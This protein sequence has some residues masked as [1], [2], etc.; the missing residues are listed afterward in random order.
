MTAGALLLVDD[1]EMN[2][3]MLGRRLELHGYTITQAEGGRQALDLLDRQ[4]FDLVL[5]DVMM[6]ELNAMDVLRRIRATHEAA[7]LPVIMVTAKDQ[8]EDVVEAFHLGANDYVTKPIDFPVALAR[9]ATQVSHKKA[10]AALRASEARFALAARG[11]ND[12]LWDWDLRTNEI[13]FSPRWQSML[14]YDAGE[15]GASPDDWFRRTHPDDIDRVRAVIAAHRDGLT[16][17]FECEQRMLHKDETYRWVLCRGL[18]IRDRTGAAERMAG[19]LTDITEGKVVDS[20]TGL[21]NRILFLDRLG[22]VLER[23][24]RHPDCQWAVLFLD[25][26]RFKVI[27][28]SL[29]HTVGDQLLVG[30]AR[31]L[32]GCLRSADTVARCH[33]DHTIARLGG[34]EF[35]ILLDDIKDIANATQVAERILREL[36]YPFI[37]NGHEVFASASIGIVPGTADYDRPEDLLRDADTAMYSAKAQGKAR[38]QVFNATMR[39]QA[40]ARLE[41]E[42]DLR[43][44][45][46]QQGF[47][48]NYQPIY[49][50]DTGQIIGFEALL[51][52]QHPQRGLISPVEFIPV[53]E[54]MGVI[55]PLGWWILREACRQISDWQE[56]FR[57]DPPLMIG[58]NFSGRQ[59]LQQDVVPQIEAILRAAGLSPSSLKL[60]ITESVIMSDPEAATAMLVHLRAL[61]VQVGIDDFGT[62]YSSLSYLHRFP[63]DT[64]KIDRSFV[65]KMEATGESA[66]M[67]QAIVALAHNLG[68]DV[69]AEGVETAEQL[70][71]LK[72]LKCEYGQGYHF[73]KPLDARTAEAL[74]AAQPVPESDRASLWASPAEVAMVS[75]E[76]SKEPV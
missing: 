49:K 32:E 52:W 11:A 42:T 14:G 3:D 27:N 54:E 61:G 39:D 31:R 75:F 23:A 17:H 47:H 19:S 36:G 29:G 68:M 56:Q 25:L 34:D 7:D 66:E 45:V 46:E 20:L 72:A 28:D 26:D 71:H 24:K 37:L 12:G 18:A 2:R 4:A 51:R 74:L 9:I 35:T 55:V 65:S 69:I 70:A 6:P 5:L 40:I 13:Y 1:E 59:F 15:V 64:L 76:T 60:E 48:L 8:S 33:G 44:A 43:R 41:L 38:Y 21:P 62:G 50:L 10:R 30:I 67:V 16:P 53:A 57:T 73:S 58:V 63:I 22:R